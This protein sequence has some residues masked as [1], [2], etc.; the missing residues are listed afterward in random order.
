MT[1]FYLSG[2]RSFNNRGCEAIVRSTT[3]IFRSILPSAKFLVPSDNINIDQ[4]HISKAKEKGIYFVPFYESRLNKFWTQAQRLSVLQKYSFPLPQPKELVNLI[5]SADAILSIGGDNYSLD[6]RIPS[7]IMSVDSIGYKFKKPVYLWGASVGPFNNA[8]KFIP[9]IKNHLSKMKLILVRESLSYQYLCHELCLE[10]VVQSSDPAFLLDF[11]NYDF[12][13]CLPKLSQEGILGLNISHIILN[14]SENKKNLFDEV[15][16]FIKLAVTK[17][18]LGVILISHVTNL[19]GRLK[20]D[21]FVFLN[22]IYKG[23]LKFKD[24]VTLMP[25]HLNSGQIK[26]LI[27]KLDFFIGSRTHSIIASM[28]SLVPC[29]TISYSIKGKGI[30]EELLEDKELVIENNNLSRI[31]LERCLEKLVKN[32]QKY[33]KNLIKNNKKIKYLVESSAAL[34]LDDLRG[35]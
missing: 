27:S 20:N 2:H 6:Y 23:L 19:D 33:R 35:R 18:N 3:S 34:V 29:G 10:N 1:I 11:D 32:N 24:N 17:Y 7:P 31:S 14:L 8:P 5:N 15:S 22:K 25:P 21:D 16:A 4:K 12:K 13:T 30:N 9:K 26:Y 28:S